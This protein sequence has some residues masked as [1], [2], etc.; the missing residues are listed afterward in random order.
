MICNY[1]CT[2]SEN[3]L[4]FNCMLPILPLFIYR[5]GHTH[6]KIKLQDIPTSAGESTVM[7][8]VGSKQKLIPSYFNILQPV[9]SI[10]F[11]FLICLEP[12][13]HPSFTSFTNVS[14]TLRRRPP[15]SPR[16]PGTLP[17]SS[18]TCRSVCERSAR[19]EASRP[20]I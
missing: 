14:L 12:S 18:R 1:M 17:T 5:H 9:K 15:I 20:A 13:F 6:N 16:S 7:F 8:E 11:Y 4:H 10:L 3:V 2:L 19:C